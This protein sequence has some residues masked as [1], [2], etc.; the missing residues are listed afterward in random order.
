MDLPDWLQAD[1]ARYDGITGARPSMEA[2][3]RHALRASGDA[4]LRSLGFLLL[5]PDALKSGG[6]ATILKHLHA[7]HGIRPVAIR[8]L[9]VRPYLFDRLYLPKAGVF[10][11]RGW[12]HH[13]I[14]ALGPSAALLVAGDR[15]EFPSLCERIQ[16]L[17]GA[18]S[19]TDARESGGLR[20]R[21]GRQSALHAVL[22]TSED[23]AALL[24]EAPLIFRVGAI[25]AAVA[26]AGS[27][28]EQAFLAGSDCDVLMACDPPLGSA[29]FESA[30][31]LERRAI[32]AMAIARP[33][34]DPLLGE[35]AAMTDEALDAVHG[36]SYPVQR[37]R[38]AAFR[39]RERAPMSRLIARCDE[40][41]RRGVA[42]DVEP[43]DETTVAERWLDLG[44]LLAPFE[45]ASACWFVA[46]HEPYRVDEGDAVFAALERHGVPVS[47]LQRT[48]IEAGLASD[49]RDLPSASATLRR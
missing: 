28:G 47:P 31:H 34:D 19:P 23:P 3:A 38:F 40:N 35:L 17:K 18:S 9:N 39:D 8:V 26:A 42:A 1:L 29:V 15:G 5:R 6:H 7:E 43:G 10:E 20:H 37:E 49:F 32:A 13:R 24:Y 4:G 41:L 12:L 36:H 14:F 45:L 16:A 22:H 21:A 48:L 11:D 44:E 33:G 2:L 30:L 25:R 46:A 27:G